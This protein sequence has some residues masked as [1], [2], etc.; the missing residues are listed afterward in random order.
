MEEKEFDEIIAEINE[1]DPWSLDYYNCSWK[2]R[3]AGL[4]DLIKSYYNLPD[5]YGCIDEQEG[6]E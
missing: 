2:W 6:D 1:L 4:E 3:E 5:T